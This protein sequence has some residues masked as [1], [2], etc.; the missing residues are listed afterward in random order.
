MPSIGLL[1]FVVADEDFY[2]LADHGAEI[3]IDVRGRCVRAAGR[4]FSFRLDDM[5]LRLV[6]SKGLAEAFRR[7]REGVYD[8]LCS[9]EGT[10]SKGPSTASLAEVSMQREG[11]GELDW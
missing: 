4:R 9:S 8:A 1:G 11:A 10:R 2:R 7:Y 6:E 5:E 3:E